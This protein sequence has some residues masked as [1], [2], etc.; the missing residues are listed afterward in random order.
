MGTRKNNNT[1]STA[2]KPI[3]SQFLK[4]V[5]NADL[6][7]YTGLKYESPDSAAGPPNKKQRAQPPK[8]TKEAPMEVLYSSDEN[9]QDGE[10]A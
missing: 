1:A 2:D 7:E 6:N 5:S 10:D 8:P 3:D 9:K 4:K